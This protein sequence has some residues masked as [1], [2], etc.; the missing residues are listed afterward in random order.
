MFNSDYD[1]GYDAGRASVGGYVPP[2]TKTCP[3][4]GISYTGTHVCPQLFKSEYDRGYDAGRDAARRQMGL[5]G[6][7]GAFEYSGDDD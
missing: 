6:D 7:C 5:P 4:C 3:T 2:L 1:R